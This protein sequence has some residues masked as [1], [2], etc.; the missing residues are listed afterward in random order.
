MSY[1]NIA[2]FYKSGN[3]HNAINAYWSP[4]FSIFIILFSFIG[5]WLV[6][7]KLAVYISSILWFI[8]IYLLAQTILKSRNKSL[9]VI[10]FITVFPL[11]Y[12]IWRLITP[13]LLFSAFLG[14]WLIFLIKLSNSKS[15]KNWFIFGILSG[16]GFLIK[17][18]F[19]SF[20]A[21]FLLL[22]F[23]LFKYGKIKVLLYFYLGLFLL[24]ICWGLLIFQ[25]YHQF[26]FNTAVALIYNHHVANQDFSFL[27]KPIKPIVGTSFWT[28]PSDFSP[29]KFNLYNQ[30]IAIT[31]NLKEAGKFLIKNFHIGLMF[32]IW[33]IMKNRKDKYVL[34]MISLILIWIGL[35][36]VIFIEPRYLWPLITPIFILIM[37]AVDNKSGSKILLFSYLIISLVFFTKN[38]LKFLPSDP[39][40][41]LHK[42]IS[43][44][45]EK[46][47]HVL[48]DSWDR[49]LY[50]SFLSGCKYNGISETAFMNNDLS[51]KLSAEIKTGRVSYFL[52]F[53]GEKY[54]NELPINLI[55]KHAWVWQNKQVVLYKVA[56]NLSNDRH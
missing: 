53:N 32:I 25:K 29:L 45:I 9:V 2:Q 20:S 54:Q 1:I 27:Q 30:M 14:F 19:L 13:D 17:S 55:E 5:D 34:L 40:S 21:I 18:Y 56:S 52:T 37:N 38:Y 4:V 51:N 22:V 8:S 44:H 10:L 42:N 31:N 24:P 49:G 39:N 11:S 43:H 48:S 41:L 26:T 46:P 15:L 28:D 47:C 16:I 33:G 50:I 23:I 12:E 36:S 6:A 35:Y 7:S 3:F